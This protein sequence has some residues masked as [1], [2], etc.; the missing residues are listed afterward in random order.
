MRKIIGVTGTAASG[1]DEVVR[2]LVR[3]IGWEHYSTS[4]EIR[5]EATARGIGHSRPELSEIA[6]ELRLGMGTSVL[7]A[8]ALA[9][10]KGDVII[11]GIRNEGEIEYLKTQGDFTLIAVDASADT[12][13]MRLRN[14]D[15]VR[16]GN[17]PDL[18][19]DKKEFAG[20]SHGQQVGKCI[21]ASDIII[22]NDGTLDELRK[23]V[24]EFASG[25]L[26]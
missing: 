8:R 16:P 13:E 10:A 21:E 23:K 12:R 14:R 2:M 1:K 25:I 18:K 20:A 11:S 26:K 19:Q 9:R 7:A 4:D 24:D 3:S 6:N 22:M 17:D 5:Y 15:E